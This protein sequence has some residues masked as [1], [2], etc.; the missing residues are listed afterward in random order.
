MFK[1][2]TYQQAVM[3]LLRGFYSDWARE[4]HS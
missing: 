1:D 4:N 2:I 3:V